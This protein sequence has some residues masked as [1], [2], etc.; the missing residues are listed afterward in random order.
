MNFLVLCLNLF[1]Q[2][3]L[4]YE[5]MGYI[6]IYLIFVIEVQ[7]IFVKLDVN[8]VIG[9]GNILVRIF[10]E[11]F[12]EFLLLFFILYN[13]LFRL[14]VVFEEWKRVIIIFVFQFGNKNLVENYW[15]VFLLFVFGKCQEKIMYYVIFYMQFYI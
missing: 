15:L 12:R 8:E 1:L 7:K 14:G 10:K 2:I 13:M 9:V 5:M 3:M 4:Y 6:W 11:C